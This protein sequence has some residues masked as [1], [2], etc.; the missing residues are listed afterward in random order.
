[1]NINDIPSISLDGE[2]PIVTSL[3]SNYTEGSGA[4]SI[5]S[6]TY[7]IDVDPNANIMRYFM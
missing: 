7:V 5:A 3:T 2:S 1:M 6:N 4:V